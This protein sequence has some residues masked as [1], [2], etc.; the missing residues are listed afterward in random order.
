MYLRT[1]SRERNRCSDART[2][3]AAVNCFETSP[4][5][6]LTEAKVKPRVRGGPFVGLTVNEIPPY[7]AKRAAVRNLAMNAQ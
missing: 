5:K 3:V 4:C 6:K 2:T 7:R 1:L